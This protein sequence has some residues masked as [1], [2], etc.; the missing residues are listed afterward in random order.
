MLDSVCFYLFGKED[1][2]VQL[3]SKSVVKRANAWYL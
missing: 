3:F 2:L 1:Q